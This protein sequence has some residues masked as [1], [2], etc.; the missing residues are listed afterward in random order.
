MEEDVH[1]HDL[2]YWDC[3]GYTYFCFEFDDVRA[4]CET[5][6]TSKENYLG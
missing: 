3:K 2:D 1:D 4:Y 5:V 6:K